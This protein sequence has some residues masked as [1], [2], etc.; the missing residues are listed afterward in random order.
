MEEGDELLNKVIG[1][2]FLGKDHLSRETRRTW[3]SGPGS[4]LGHEHSRKQFIVS[5]AVLKDGWVTFVQAVQ[6]CI[7]CHFQL[8]M[9]TPKQLIK[10]TFL[11]LSRLAARDRSLVC[12]SAA[13]R[14]QQL[15]TGGSPTSSLGPPARVVKVAT[16]TLAMPSGPGPSPLNLLILL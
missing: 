4:W 11:G 9:S 15:E 2:A 7:P 5:N 10:E 12:A 1:T 8:I 16:L 3:E 13:M 14:D 6:P